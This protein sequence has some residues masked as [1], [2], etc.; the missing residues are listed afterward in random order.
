MLFVKDISS[1]AYYNV[2]LADLVDQYGNNQRSFS[3]SE[4][5]IAFVNHF[6]NTWYQVVVNQKGTKLSGENYLPLSNDFPTGLQDVQ[7]NV[8]IYSFGNGN[9]SQTTIPGGFGAG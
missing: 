2:I 9:V 3:T 8:P 7:C 1:S 4:Q 5:L 6:A